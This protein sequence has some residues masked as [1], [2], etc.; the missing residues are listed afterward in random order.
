MIA[1]VWRG[2][3]KPEDAEAYAGFLSAEL[4][5]AVAARVG[6]FRCGFVFRR[7]D[8]SDVEFLVM[9]VFESLD[10]VR[11][12]AGDDVDVPVIEPEAARL[13]IRGDDRV[14]HFDV[15]LRQR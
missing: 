3:T 14:E 11:R 7:R 5:P 15:R 13:L 2:W 12:F 9:T 6:G 1:R 8:G 4:F 10:D